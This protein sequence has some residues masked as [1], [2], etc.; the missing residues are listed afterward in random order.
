MKPKSRSLACAQWIPFHVERGQGGLSHLF[1]GNLVQ[2]PIQTTDAVSTSNKLI[3]DYLFNRRR[4]LQLAAVGGASLLIP[5]RQSE[6][7]LGALIGAAVPWFL[8]GAKWLATTVLG[9]AVNYTVERIIREK[10]FGDFRN[11]EGAQPY[12]NRFA[13]AVRIE[14]S[15]IPG[16]VSRRYK[17]WDLELGY[18]PDVGYKPYSHN[19]AEIRS[20]YLLEYHVQKP[21]EKAELTPEAI[22]KYDRKFYG[23]IARSREEF[24]P[25]ADLERQLEHANYRTFEDKSKYVKVAEIEYVG[26]FKNYDGEEYTGFSVKR[27]GQRMILAHV[28]D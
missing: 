6:A 20:C 17:G 1:H 12:H 5:A 3:D 2:N 18:E 27:N 9:A 28:E 22:E 24:K 13:D 21:G 26:N 15:V 7:Q 19:T 10:L 23:L 16:Y 14:R 25:T 11:N 8:A 4:A